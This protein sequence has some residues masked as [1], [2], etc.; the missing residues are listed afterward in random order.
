MPHRETPLL[1]WMEG[2]NCKFEWITHCDITMVGRDSAI[3]FE[4]KFPSQ[5]KLLPGLSGALLRQDRVIFS[6]S[7]SAVVERGTFKRKMWPWKYSTIFYAFESK[8][9]QFNSS[10]VLFQWCHQILWT[11]FSTGHILTWIMQQRRTSASN[12][13]WLAPVAIISLIINVWQGMRAIWCESNLKGKV[14]AKMKGWK[15]IQ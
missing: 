7:I 4:S 11:L 10:F 3:K 5:K 2:E 12:C 8:R 13:C 1:I 14:R 6:T 9:D 15:G